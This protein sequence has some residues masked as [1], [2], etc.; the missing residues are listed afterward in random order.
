MSGWLTALRIAR[1]E[2]RRAKGRTALVMALIGLP[3]LALS[4]AAVSYDM[5]T[6]TA[7]EQLAREIGTADA[8]LTRVASGPVEQDSTGGVLAAPAEEGAPEAETETNVAA[9]LPGLTADQVRALLPTASHVSSHWYGEVR[10]STATGVGT[11]RAEAFD[12]TDRLVEGIARVTD[13]RTP[14]G[15]TE[16][17]LTASAATRLGVG[18][19]DQLELVESDHHPAGRYRVTGLVEFPDRVATDRLARLVPPVGDVTG[20]DSAAI[21]YQATVV[22]HPD[23]RPGAGWQ[24]D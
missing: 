3:V 5:F 15:A 24:T 21:A 22:F 2:A 7:Q 20:I 17:A 18:I 14:A 11:L 6:L 10:A 9:A 1:R 8:R 16:V 13:G 4:F 19:G 23:G 12:L